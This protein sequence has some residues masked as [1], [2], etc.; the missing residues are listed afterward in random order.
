MKDALPPLPRPLLSPATMITVLPARTEGVQ[1]KPVPWE[2]TV[3]IWPSG[4]SKLCP[5][6]IR[7][8]KVGVLKC[9][10]GIGVEC[11]VMVELF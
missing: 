6:G 11:D 10:G 3:V 2:S 4:I 1:E 8:W 7:P 5:P 9:I